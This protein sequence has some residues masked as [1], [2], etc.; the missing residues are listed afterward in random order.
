MERTP[1]DWFASGLGK[2][3]V[4]Y[5]SPEW[6]RD[7]GRAFDPIFLVDQL[8]DSGVDAVE[9]YAKDHHGTLYYP[10][11]HGLD[12]GRDV[13]GELASACRDRGLRFIGYISVCLDEH[14]AGLHPD[15]LATDALGQARTMRPFRWLCVRSPYRALLLRQIETLAASYDIDGL[16]LDILPIAW[17]SPYTTTAL[18]GPR[19][20]MLQDIVPC[21]CHACRSQF[22]DEW[23][24]PALLTPDAA[25]ADDLFAFGVRG[26]RSLLDDVRAI[27]QR[28]RPAAFLTYNGAGAPGDAVDA[29]DLVSVE[30]HAPFYERQGL[31]ARW[32]HGRGLPGEIMAAGAVP[33]TPSGWNGFDRKP[34]PVLELERA[35]TAAHG[36]ST[37]FG[38]APYTDGHSDAV[39]F[40]GIRAVGRSFTSIAARLVAP[41]SVAD[42]LLASTI[43]PVTAPRLWGRM[44][45]SLE[46]W[47]DILRRSHQQYDIGGLDRDL[48][49]YSLIVLPDQ[50]AM[51][52]AEIEAVRRFVHA[53]GHLLATGDTSRLDERGRRRDESGLADVFGARTTVEAGS[54]FTIISR[55]DPALADGLPGTPIVINRSHA[56]AQA[57]TGRPILWTAQPER[58]FADGST[59][60]W[61]YPPPDP[62]TETA[63]GFRQAFGAGESIFLSVPLDPPAGQSGPWATGGLEAV[64][65][66][67]LARG[68]VHALLPDPVVATNAPM[69]VEVVLQRHADH[70]MLHLMDYAAGDAR[71][72]TE[73][74]SRRPLANL[75]V[76]IDAALVPA[77][78]CQTRDGRD[79]SV[80]V[81]DDR[82]RLTVPGFEVSDQL[83]LT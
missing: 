46:A 81:S 75:T 26:V 76:S 56:L 55:I 29:G 24:Y 31:V 80:E 78:R 66:S 77:T 21:Y 28:H 33:S 52:D 47:H 20:W 53:G 41:A 71:H 63:A 51:S 79:V 70:W 4:L 27:L 22:I 9:L 73:V 38:H 5:V 13:V 7:R 58:P 74:A 17:P 49:S 44:F 62:A 39:Q 8:A 2:S 48:S 61:G 6:A 16:W 72:V 25:G 11:P 69:S 50:A 67:A 32:A 19:L 10:F 45:E 83:T 59:M 65:T 42:V 14:A 43:K 60:L 12:Y 34:A 35:V 36:G 37:T 64:W 54:P 23:G 18:G 1:A 15:W 82:L 30:G 3:H 57:T 68:L 40:D